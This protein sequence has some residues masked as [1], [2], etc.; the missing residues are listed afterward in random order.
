M[1]IFGDIQKRSLSMMQV[2]DYS[3]QIASDKFHVDSISNRKK[4]CC[5]HVDLMTYSCKTWIRPIVNRA[6]KRF[7]ER[8]GRRCQRFIFDNFDLC[9][10]HG[11]PDLFSFP[12]KKVI[13][14]VF[15]PPPPNRL[16]LPPPLPPD[17]INSY[18]MCKL[19][20]FR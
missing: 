4:V 10:K 2:F 3:H 16:S 5:L 13:C 9:F 14:T 11:I 20:Y 19:I 18:L 1:T 8:R 12:R 6:K 7:Q 17:Y 15:T